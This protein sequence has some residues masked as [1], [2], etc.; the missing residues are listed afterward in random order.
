MTIF[1]EKKFFWSCFYICAFHYLYVCGRGVGSGLRHRHVHLNIASWGQLALSTMWVSGTEPI[2]RLLDKAL[3][4]LLCA[5]TLLPIFCFSPL[6]SCY[7]KP[8]SFTSS[9]I[10]FCK[11]KFAISI[12]VPS[13]LCS[14]NRMGILDLT[15]YLFTCCPQ[16]VCFTH[17]HEDL[18]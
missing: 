15:L 2:T 11:P 17:Y 1:S 16:R 8:P 7:L 14:W 3:T 5:I 10:I 9:D 12:P 4:H 18:L 6:C 13:V